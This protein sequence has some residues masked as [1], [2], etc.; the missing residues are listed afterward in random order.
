MRSW[1]KAY[2]LSKFVISFQQWQA[3]PSVYLTVY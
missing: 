2:Q 1:L 3:Y